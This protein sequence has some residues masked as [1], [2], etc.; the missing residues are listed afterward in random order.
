MKDR[1]YIS[2]QRDNFGG[3]VVFHKK[4]KRG[5]TTN[6]GEAEELNRADAQNDWDCGR[7]FD[8][9]LSADHVDAVALYF[10]DMQVIPH[11]TTITDE[12]EYVAF[13]SG[14]YSGN[15]A[16]FVKDCG[17]SYIYTGAKVFTREEAKKGLKNYVF[18][19][20]SLAEQN[21]RLCLLVDLVDNRKFITGAG[22]KIPD[23]IKRERRRS[24]TGLTR[25]NCPKCGKINWQYNP[26][27]FM[28]CSD[29]ICDE[30][31]SVYS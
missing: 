5:Y 14:A 8:V 6:I 3:K 21:K 29:I 26:Y 15:D 30:Y 27:D 10:V 12:Q 19:P 16:L 2:C 31:R 28:G 7:E 17:N 22:I 13:L 25:W 1:F 11:E 9:P 4:G 18:I 24:Q 23:R 20:K